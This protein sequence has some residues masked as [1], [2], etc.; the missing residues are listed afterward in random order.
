MAFPTP[1]DSLLEFFNKTL[2][3]GGSVSIQNEKNHTV[4]ADVNR[5]QCTPQLRSGEKNDFAQNSLVRAD[6]KKGET[7]EADVTSLL[8]GGTKITKTNH[9]IKAKMFNKE[10]CKFAEEQCWLLRRSAHIVGDQEGKDENNVFM[11]CSDLQ[12]ADYD[13]VRKLIS[14]RKNSSLPQ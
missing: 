12:T 6:N 4:L 3:D 8:I 1:C 10:K 9:S 5:L 11:V 2:R 14:E 13:N 7:F